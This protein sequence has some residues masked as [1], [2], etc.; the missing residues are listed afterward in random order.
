LMGGPRNVEAD[1]AEAAVQ[2]ATNLALQV[3]GATIGVKRT[4]ERFGVVR[5]GNS[6]ITRQEHEAV[7]IAQQRAASAAKP[8]ET[9]GG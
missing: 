3:E 5:R 6:L 4:Y 2:F 1:Q 7:K 9:S 8:P